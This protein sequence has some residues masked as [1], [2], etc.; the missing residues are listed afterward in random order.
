M[1]LLIT[2][3][4]L[5]IVNVVVGLTAGVGINNKICWVFK[6]VTDNG[7]V[8]VVKLVVITLF[9]SLM[10]SSVFVPAIVTTWPPVSVPEMS[11]EISMNPA[12][13]DGKIC[14]KAGVVMVCV[15]VVNVPLR[16]PIVRV[17]TVE[18]PGRLAV[19]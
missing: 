9:E 16:N 3:L 10:A 5:S 4:V 2:K 6:K 7:A 8:E 14:V 12:L 18:A 1:V 15:T 19:V 11:A 17:E 13:G